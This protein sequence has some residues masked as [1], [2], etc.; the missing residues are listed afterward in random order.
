VVSICGFQREVPTA[1]SSHALLA[2][3]CTPPGLE[4]KEKEEYTGSKEL[5]ASIKSGE[6][7]SCPA[8]Y[9]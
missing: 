9:T 2:Y 3:T 8:Y 4:R 6:P 1:A 7:S 5:P